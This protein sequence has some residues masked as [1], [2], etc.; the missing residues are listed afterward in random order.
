MQ[1]LPP[2]PA[3]LA[4]IRIFYQPVVRLAD[5]RTEYV[6]VLA[7]AAAA[8]GT[9]LGPESIV[10]AMTS[11]E[12]SMRL[13]AGIL[14]RSL[15]EYAEFNFAGQNLGLAFNLPLDAMLHP[16]LVAR[17][18]AI[19]A[20]SR[21]A[22]RNT[23]FELTERHPVHD[24]NAARTVIIALHE[25]GF[26]LALDDITPGMP[27]LE[28]LLEMPIRAIKLDRSVVTSTASADRAFI[29]AM[30]A[31]ATPRRQNI[32]AEGIETPELRDQMREL[33]V[34]HGQGF[35]FSHPLPAARLR[36]FLHGDVGGGVLSK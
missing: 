36:T 35:L 34:T 15:D 14:Q 32:I 17:I 27:Y 19:R 22:A 2:D 21:L 7:R 30:I 24:L 12:R 5:L 10:E 16:E 29:R 18:E 20:G 13:T 25:A 26:S 8:D 33:G 4:S 28:A 1:E 9:L 11:P 23:H 31:Q 6:E 3:L